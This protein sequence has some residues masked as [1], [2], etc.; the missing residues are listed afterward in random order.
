MPL[1]RYSPREI[2]ALKKLK[3]LRAAGGGEDPDLEGL[4][5]LPELPKGEATV[6]IFIPG[7]LQDDTEE[8]DDS[9]T[10]EGD[11]PLGGAEDTGR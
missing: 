5:D 9:D 1:K 10:G 7:D 8:L 3:S 6:A 4:P 11:I 2:E